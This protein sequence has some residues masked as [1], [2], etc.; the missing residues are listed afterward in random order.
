MYFY[1]LHEGDNDVFADLLLGHEEEMDPDEFFQTVKTV[2]EHVIGSYHHDTLI[3]AIAEELERDYGFVYIS[4]ARLTAAV[5][6]SQDPDETFLAG[7]DG[8]RLQ[9][10]DDDE[11]DEDDGDARPDYKAILV[12]FDPDAI[13]RT[14][15]H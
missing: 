3:E 9:A 14:R 8:G 5:N 7:T 2:R 6:V 11:D 4:D 1:E 10:D 12:D 15:P 13:G